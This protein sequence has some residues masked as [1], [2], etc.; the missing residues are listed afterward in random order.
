MLKRVEEFELNGKR[1]IVRCDFNVPIE[2]G[3][4][5]DDW[6]IKIAIPTIRFLLQ[7]GASIILISHLGDPE[8]KVIE[9]L[10]LDI[11]RKRLQALL[12]MEIKKS[13]DVL[14]KETREKAL[15]LKSG[16]ILLLENIRFYPQEE[17]GDLSFAKQLSQLGEIFIN[18]AFS[19]SHRAHSSVVGICNFLPSGV[20]F[21]FQKELEQLTFFLKNY[22]RPLVILVGGKKVKDKAGVLKKFLEIGDWIL[23]NHLI[24][25]ELK[26]HNIEILKSS[27]ILTPIDTREDGKDIG[28]KTIQLFKEKIMSAKYIF[29]NGP[30]GQIEN[31]NAREG[32]RQLALAILESQAFSL[33]GGG[34][35]IEFTNLLGI[36]EKFSY[37]SSGGGAMLKFLSGE[38]LPALQALGYY[39]D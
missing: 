21:L 13:E 30:F 28:P 11:V 2:G 22:K 23:I 1:V 16:E 31:E 24:W 39:G 34:E 14:S 26:T 36:T 33:I 5:L 27:K 12:D 15:S 37:A 4:I 7:N 18:E 35:T 8:G 20:G 3:V 32:T 9:E 29:W 10:R 19:V 6:R 17:Q 25:K 38:K